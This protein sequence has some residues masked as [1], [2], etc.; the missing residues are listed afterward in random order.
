MKVVTAEWDEI[1]WYYTSI[2][3]AFDGCP[4]LSIGAGGTTVFNE[5]KTAHPHISVECRRPTS[6]LRQKKLLVMLARRLPAPVRD[7]LR[8]WEHRL[9]LL[10]EP[11]R[12]DVRAGDGEL[13][14]LRSSDRV[15]ILDDAIDTGATIK[16][17]IDRL[18]GAGFQ[19]GVTTVVFAWTNPRSLVRPDFWFRESML[20]KFPWSHDL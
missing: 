11:G 4:V 15:V 16:A 9:L 3:G 5:L 12:R 14:R 6:D 1:R 10:F 8:S 18:R 7:L 19:G 2:L 13:A 17:V 20:V